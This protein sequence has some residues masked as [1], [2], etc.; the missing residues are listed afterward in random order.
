MNYIPKELD[1]EFKNEITI[2]GLKR[3]LLASYSG[4]VFVPF[5]IILDIL[6]VPERLS[7]FIKLRLICV[8]VLFL[9]ARLTKSNANFV[10][11]HLLLS[12]FA[13]PLLLLHR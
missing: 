10:R 11:R 5:F 13:V 12:I 9:I 2:L 1:A 8:L 7:L 3:L 6:V 4:M